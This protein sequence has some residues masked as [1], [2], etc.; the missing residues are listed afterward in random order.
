MSVPNRRSDFNQ[1][2]E[3]IHVTSQPKA[4][5]IRF[6]RPWLFELQLKPRALALACAIVQWTLK[7]GWCFYSASDLARRLGWSAR[8]VERGLADLAQAQ[9]LERNRR[10]IRI[11]PPQQTIIK[12]VESSDNA[13]LPSDNPGGNKRRTSDNGGGATKHTDLKKKQPIQEER[14]GQCSIERST[15]DLDEILSSLQQASR[16]QGVEPDPRTRRKRGWEVRDALRDGWTPEEL[17][18]AL[19]GTLDDGW[20]LRHGVDPIAHAARNTGTY[21]E[22]G[23]GW[24]EGE[25]AKRREEEEARQLE[26]ASRK[27]CETENG[28]HTRERLT[29]RPTY[30][31]CTDCGFIVRFEPGEED[32]VVLPKGLKMALGDRSEGCTLPAIVGLA[33]GESG[34]QAEQ[35]AVSFGR[36]T[37]VESLGYD[38]TFPASTSAQAAEVSGER[39]RRHPT[40]ELVNIREKIPELLRAAGCHPKH[41]RSDVVGV[42]EPVDAAEADGVVEPQEGSSKSLGPTNPSEIASGF[43]LNAD[44]LPPIPRASSCRFS[45]DS[46]EPLGKREAFPT[47]STGPPSGSFKDVREKKAPGGSDGV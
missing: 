9:I 22:A 24:K 40:S 47:P 38:G 8:T 45:S 43:S 46:R 25:E 39:R 19:L 33:D 11:V 30:A 4:E 14:E 32:S 5:V 42:K 16:D 29:W 12:T 36:D 31:F 27:R 41:R 1:K 28:P 18:F 15:H 10:G 23:R 35:Q 37:E 44:H 2:P 3:E 20:A 26:E 21:V 13:A 17:Q 34:A 6:P 7:K